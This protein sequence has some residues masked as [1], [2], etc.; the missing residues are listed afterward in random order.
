MQAGRKN[1]RTIDSCTH[2]HKSKNIL[3]RSKRRVSP[4]LVRCPNL[5]TVR[6]HDRLLHRT[7]R[8][9]LPGNKGAPPPP[10]P[11]AAGAVGPDRRADAAQR[12][13]RGGAQV[14]RRR[15]GRRR[16]RVRRPFVAV[17][18][19]CSY[20]ALA[21][22]R[23]PVCACTRVCWCRRIFTYIHTS[24]AVGCDATRAAVTSHASRCGRGGVRLVAG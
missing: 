11:G 14:A 24:V 20:G 7:T 4:N 8:Y 17:H 1:E 12:R 13:A 6:Q 10:P 9:S 2:D 16:D 22:R 3:Y 15:A 23:G 5:G 19:L 18:V 21:W